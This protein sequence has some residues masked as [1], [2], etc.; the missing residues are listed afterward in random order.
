MDVDWPLMG[1]LCAGLLG[2]TLACRI[3]VYTFHVFWKAIRA[4]VGRNRQ[5]PQSS[6]SHPLSA[7]SLRSSL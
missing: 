3:L 1:F 7:M 2:V 6:A 4:A 5:E